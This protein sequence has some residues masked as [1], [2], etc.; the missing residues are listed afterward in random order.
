MLRRENEK[1]LFSQINPSKASR[2]RLI[3]EAVT[4]HGDS[5]M[6]LASSP[7]PALFDDQTNPRSK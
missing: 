6:E 4:A 5:E 2:D 3:A 1:K 7:G